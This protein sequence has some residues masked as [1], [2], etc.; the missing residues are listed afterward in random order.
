MLH[1]QMGT[2]PDPPTHL[3]FF[4]LASTPVP[5]PCRPSS[6]LTEV[7]EDWGGGQVSPMTPA[8]PLEEETQVRDDDEGWGQGRPRMEFPD[9]AVAL[10]LPVEVAVAMHFVEGVAV[11][12]KG[13]ESLEANKGPWS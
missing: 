2:D 1:L 9:E 12:A 13:Q 6:I 3:P 10:R 4:P 7:L 11:E 8:Q 5:L